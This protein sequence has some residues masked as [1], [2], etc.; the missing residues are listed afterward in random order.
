MIPDRATTI[1]S[2]LSTVADVISSLPARLIDDVVQAVK[3]AYE[4]GKQVLICGNGGSAS[5]ASHLACDL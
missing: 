4:Q 5:T 3:Q 1:S 2:Y